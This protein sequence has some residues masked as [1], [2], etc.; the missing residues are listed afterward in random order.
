M[1][2]NTPKLIFYSL[3]FLGLVSYPF[4]AAF[5]RAMYIFGFPLLYVYLFFIW[6]AFISILYFLSKTLSKNSRGE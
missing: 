1:Q 4:V 2:I 5:D 6:A 3:L